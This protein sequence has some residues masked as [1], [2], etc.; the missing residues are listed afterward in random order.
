LAIALAYHEPNVTIFAADLSLEAIALARRNIALHGLEDRIV[1]RHGDLFAPF[2]RGDFHGQ[3]DLIV[4]NPPYIS[5]SKVKTLP[6]EISQHEPTLAFDGGPLGVNILSRLL[7]EAPTFLKAE[8]WL[9]FEIGLG[10]GDYFHRCL[11][12]MTEFAQVERFADEK[13]AT[14]ALAAKTP[15]GPAG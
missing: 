5:S 15:P 4:C 14:R 7:K 13:G 8:S 3:M 9:C 11:S 2:S 10:Q 1:V 6:A 12:R